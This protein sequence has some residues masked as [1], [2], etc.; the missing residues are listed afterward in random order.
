MV[1]NWLVKTREGQQSLRQFVDWL[2]FLPY[3]LTPLSILNFDNRR[4]LKH[5]LN[6]DLVLPK[7]S[8]FQ[9][10]LNKLCKKILCKYIFLPALFDTVLGT[11]SCRG[12]VENSLFLFSL[13]DNLDLFFWHGFKFLDYLLLIVWLIIQSAAW[14]ALKERPMILLLRYRQKYQPLSRKQ[15]KVNLLDMHS[16][17]VYNMNCFLISSI[18]PSDAFQLLSF[19]CCW[20]CLFGKLSELAI[21]YLY[22]TYQGAGQN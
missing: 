8:I 1:W 15:Q 20:I 9:S 6:F 12:Q 21:Y 13:R 10:K 11:V 4:P 3:Q 14:R 16:L 19:S 18:G 2:N 22:E 17:E 5:R 7:P